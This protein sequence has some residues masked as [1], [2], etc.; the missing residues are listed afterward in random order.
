VLA[1]GAVVV[2][3]L[4]AAIVIVVSAGSSGTSTADDKKGEEVIK[5]K[6]TADLAPKNETDAKVAEEKKREADYHKWMNQGQQAR[7]EKKW[8]DA[9]VA[10]QEALKI[11]PGDADAIKGKETAAAALKV[12]PNKVKGKLPKTITNSI[13]M[14][15]VLIPAGKFT[16]GSPRSEADSDFDREEQHEVQIS[17]AFYLGVYEVTQKQYRAVMGKN[18]SW[19]SSAGAGKDKVRGLDTDDFPV[20]HVSWDDAFEFCKNLS[21]LPKEQEAGREYRL[22]TEAQWEYA[23]RGGAASTEPFNIDGKPSKSLSST[24]AN[25]NGN[26]PYAG[27]KGPYLGRTCKVGSYRPNG[28][29]L[30][31]MH[32][33]VREWCAD[34][35]DKDYYGK[36]PRKDPLGPDNGSEERVFRGG[37]WDSTGVYCRAAHRYGWRRDISNHNIT[38]FRVALVPAR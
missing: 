25:F 34:C 13:G 19:F 16:M 22:P 29:G 21:A 1:L 17:K 9:V 38:G 31:D 30:Y 27:E 8:G 20:E 11:K 3:A 33:N 7:D 28:F 26:I 32:G 36:S 10:Y 23:C 6:K 18:P 2:V 14:R 15:L 35:Y 5:D 37:A 4:V 24:Q 12:E